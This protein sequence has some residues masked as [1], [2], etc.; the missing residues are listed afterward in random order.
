MKF[1]NI[2]KKKHGSLV[3]NSMELSGFL[4][5]LLGS[6]IMLAASF[7]IYQISISKAV[8]FWSG[9]IFVAL[10]FVFLIVRNIGSKKKK[11]LRLLVNSIR[12]FSLILLLMFSTALLIYTRN[13]LLVFW[14]TW[15]WIIWALLG[16]IVVLLL[17]IGLQV[18][19]AMKKQQASKDRTITTEN[20]E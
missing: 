12:V 7:G 1:A 11:N 4:F 5:I 15:A 20:K 17:N 10:G 19:L 9:G 8:M 14:P 2:F 6:I 16:M 13:N 3:G 18:A